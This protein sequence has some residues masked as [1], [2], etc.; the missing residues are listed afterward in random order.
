MTSGGDVLL[1]ALTTVIRDNRGM[2]EAGRFELRGTALQAA[3]GGGSV[4]VGRSAVIPHSFT[5][6]VGR[7]GRTIPGSYEARVLVQGTD[8]EG[9][10]VTAEAGAYVGRFP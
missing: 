4:G 1:D 2:Q 3:A 10:S 5:L 8:E 7:P 9:R 6:E